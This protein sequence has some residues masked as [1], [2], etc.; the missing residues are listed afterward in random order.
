MSLLVKLIQSFFIYCNEVRLNK[1]IDLYLTEVY[2]Y[3]LLLK[4]V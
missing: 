2:N 1:I 4:V 3:P